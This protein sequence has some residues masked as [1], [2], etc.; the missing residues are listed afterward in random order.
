MSTS[1]EIKDCKFSNEEFSDMSRL[2]ETK[3]IL[4]LEEINLKLK[5]SVNNII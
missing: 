2:G 5:V 1:Q 4:L 3:M